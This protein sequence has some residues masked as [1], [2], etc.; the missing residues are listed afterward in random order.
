MDAWFGWLLF[1]ALASFLALFAGRSLFLRFAHGVRVFTLLRGKPLSEKVVETLFLIAFPAWVADVAWH[2]WPGTTAFD[3]VIFT[4]TLTRWIGAPM[5]V[6]AVLFFACALASFGRSWRVGV[7]HSSPGE[8]VTTGVFALSRNPIFLAMDLF[9][10]GTALMTGRVLPFVVALVAIPAFHRQ[11]LNEERFLAD[12][13]GESYR[14]YRERVCRYLGRRA[15]ATRPAEH[16]DSA[17][18]LG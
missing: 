8:L 9:V 17:V 10:A 3:P 13:Y 6:A 7:D 18:E 5:C 2:A 4:T 15:A 14:K 12:H 11:I 1:G 16:R